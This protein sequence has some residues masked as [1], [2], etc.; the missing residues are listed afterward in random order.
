MH[1]IS[2]P[3]YYWDACV[4]LSWIDDTLNR[5]AIIEAIL[6]DC[7]DKKL[8]IYTSS[9][10]ITEV[11]F[12]PTEKD[13]KVLDRQVEEKIDSLWLPPSPI[14]LVDMYQIMA[15]EAKRLI[16]EAITRGWSLKP[17]DAIHLATAKDIGVSEFHTYDE[18]LYKFSKMA[19]Y[20]ILEPHTDGLPLT[21]EEDDG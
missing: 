18:S 8:E 7:E 9:F 6:T 21:V 2:R 10:S 5:A 3:K 15:F 11:A 20:K 1:K 16:R 14:K 13:K 19:G 4:F 17:V 12:S